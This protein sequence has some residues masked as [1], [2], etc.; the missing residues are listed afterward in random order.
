[1]THTQIEIAFVGFL[2]IGYLLWLRYMLRTEPNRT[3]THSEAK[4]AEPADNEKT[5]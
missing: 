3:R 1:M 4:Q 5:S 2:A